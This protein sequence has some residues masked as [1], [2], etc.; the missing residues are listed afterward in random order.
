MVETADEVKFTE[1]SPVQLFFDLLISM[2]SVL[3]WWLG[4]SAIALLELIFRSIV[5]VIRKFCKCCLCCRDVNPDP[6]QP[7]PPP[8][9]DSC[10]PALS[11]LCKCCQDD[12]PNQE[13]P[14]TPSPLPLRTPSLRSPSLRTPSPRTPP[15]RTSPPRTPLRTPTPRTHPRRTSPPQTPPHSRTP[16]PTNSRVIHPIENVPPIPPSHDDVSSETQNPVPSF[17]LKDELPKKRSKSAISRIQD[18][19]LTL[20]KPLTPPSNKVHDVEMQNTS[21]GKFDKVL[22]DVNKL[23]ETQDDSDPEV[24]LFQKRDLTRT[25]GSPSAS[26]SQDTAIS[27][28]FHGSEDST[29]VSPESNVK[30]RK[31]KGKKAVA[32]KDR[33]EWRN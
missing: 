13:Q 12:T 23:L 16:S 18:S 14:R 3:G 32:L 9:H 10:N 19:L 33:P 27:S 11:F 2:E 30:T 29:H 25:S 20:L 26:T 1:I 7:L 17:T 4:L 28:Q 22:V 31:R 6:E 5:W 8:P 15:R 24:I 21:R